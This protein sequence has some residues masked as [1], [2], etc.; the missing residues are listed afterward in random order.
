MTEKIYIRM[1]PSSQRV[2]LPANPPPSCKD[3]L[4]TL[5]VGTLREGDELVLHSRILEAGKQY[6][7]VK[8][9]TAAFIGR[10]CAE[11]A[12]PLL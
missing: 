6:T 1:A 7:F 4:D 9:V 11:V 2:S 10:V 5:G 12:V 8:E 3:V